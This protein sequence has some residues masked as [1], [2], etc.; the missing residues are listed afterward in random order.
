VSRSARLLDLVHLLA[1]RRSR[2]VG[3]IAERFSVSERTIFRDLAE[4]AERH[5]PLVRDEHGY[6]LLDTATL[7]P[8][9]FTAEEHA[10]LKVALHNPA[11]RHQPSLRTT[12]D[13]L[14]AKLDAASAQ[15]EESPHAL[16]LA[17]VDRSGPRAEKAIQP[18]ERS[19]AGRRSVDIR[20][21]SLSGGRHQWRRLDPWQLFQRAGAWYVVGWCH[22]NRE[23]RIFR[24]DRISGIRRRQE[25]YAIPDDFD[26]ELFLEDAWGLVVGNRLWE[27]ELHFDAG[28]G[29]LLLNARHHAGE[30]V[31]KLADGTIRYRVTLSSLAEIA[32]WVLTF[33]GRCRV[34]EPEELKELV[35]QA[36]REILGEHSDA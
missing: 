34:M 23:P 5:I 12:L 15:A 35:A 8:L 22:R 31:E 18:L 28:V 1:G 21:D 4:L 11:L 3:E 25:S 26:L 14:E 30:H 33:G 29:P 20:Y 32:A 17:G 24:L 19:I 36:A 13:A 10:L 2:P 16:Q 7:R 27:I 9:N 6:R